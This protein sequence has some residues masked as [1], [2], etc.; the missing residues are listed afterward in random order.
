MN[1]NLSRLRVA[2]IFGLLAVA[3]GAMGAHGLKTHWD[4]TLDVAEAARRLDVWRTAA[5]Y[6]LVHAVVLLVLAFAFQSPQKGRW[7][8]RS[9]IAGILIFSG[10]LYVLCLT[11]INKL[12]AITPIGGL[13][14]MVGWLLLAFQRNDRK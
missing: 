3:L 4:S 8:W 10:S 14:L 7:A 11:G 2:A 1:A 9:F 5:L 13:L 6:H 12:G